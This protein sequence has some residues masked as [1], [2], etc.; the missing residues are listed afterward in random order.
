MG[1]QACR[2]SV[3]TQFEFSQTSTSV[4]ITYGTQ[5]KM[6]SISFI[7][8]ITYRKLKHGNSLLRYTNITRLLY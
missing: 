4:S 5:E 8:Y 7:K 2:A 3:S 1:T 6:F